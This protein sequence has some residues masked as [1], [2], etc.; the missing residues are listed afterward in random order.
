MHTKLIVVVAA[1]LMSL[2]MV[3]VAQAQKVGFCD[4]RRLSTEVPQI[5]ERLQEVEAQFQPRIKQFQA[6]V[7][8]FEARAQ[9]FQRDQATMA[10]AERTKTER[11]LRDTQISLGRKQ[12]EIEEDQQLAQQEVGH[13]IEVEVLAEVERVAKA[14]GY[15]LIVRDAA[16]RSDSIDITQ[17]VLNSLSA[18]AKTAA[19]ATPAAPPAAKPSSK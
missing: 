3:S 17:A 14:Q 2:G 18:K 12:K 6:Q 19:P 4:F 11:E 16:F 8:D 7:K 5:R 13:K 10:D 15:D 1:G 9:K